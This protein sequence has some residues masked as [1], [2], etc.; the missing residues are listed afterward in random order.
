M[1]VTS[2]SLAAGLLLWYAALFGASEG[3]AQGVSLDPAWYAC[4]AHDDC[5]LVTGMCGGPEAANGRHR[6]S[7]EAAV[8]ELRR[9][10]AIATTGAS[11]CV[12][13]TDDPFAFARAEC[14]ELSDRKRCV[15]KYAPGKKPRF[16]V[17]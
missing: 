11:R 2:P 13:W 12:K 3:L 15:V 1:K 9:Q 6:A 17:P 4:S 5:V 8:A 14:A 16:Q 10:N 7:V